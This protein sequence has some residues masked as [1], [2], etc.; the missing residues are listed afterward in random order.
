MLDVI[1]FFVNFHC[2]P[3]DQ[4]PQEGFQMIYLLLCRPWRGSYFFGKQ[5]YFKK[6]VKTKKSCR[7]T[8]N[9]T[10]AA[11]GTIQRDPPFWVQPALSPWQPRSSLWP[12]FHSSTASAPPPGLPEDSQ[13]IPLHQHTDNC[14]KIVKAL[15]RER[16]ESQNHLQFLYELLLL[17]L[18]NKVQ[19]T[20]CQLISL[21]AF[22]HG[23]VN[24]FWA[25]H[26]KYSAQLPGQQTRRTV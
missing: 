4:I 23:V 25:Q 24:W 12:S 3:T 7:N 21:H 9:S 8:R 2:H 11:W 13:D 14:T 22:Q 15:T 17:H 19:V 20:C 6:L 18:F 10:V 26:G 1:L 16:E 5:S